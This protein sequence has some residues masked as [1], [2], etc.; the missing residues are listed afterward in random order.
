MRSPTSSP[1]SPDALARA[2]EARVAEGADAG[3]RTLLCVVPGVAAVAFLADGNPGVAGLLASRL[4]AALGVPSLVMGGVEGPDGVIAVGSGRVPDGSP[5]RELDHASS[6]GLS[7]GAVARGLGGDGGG[8]AAAFG[9]RLPMGGDPSARG[10]LLRALTLGFAQRLVSGLGAA[11]ACGT[12]VPVATDRA[13]ATRCDLSMSSSRLGLPFASALANLGPFGAGL[14]EPLIHVRLSGTSI[15]PMGTGGSFLVTGGDLS[16]DCKVIGFGAT[17][18]GG[19]SDPDFARSVRAA[20]RLSAVG[21]LRQ[22][23]YGRGSR[24]WA[25]PRPELVLDAILSPI[26]TNP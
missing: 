18:G 22:S 15:R 26:G 24:D 9:V 5:F 16:P 6:P 13:G 17:F 2:L 3:D 10:P 7:A 23:F 12:L 14:G 20:P 8:H 4:G 25:G 1:L 11:V 21:R 19:L